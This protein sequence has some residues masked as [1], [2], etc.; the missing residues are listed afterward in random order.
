MVACG[1]ICIGPFLFV[2][3]LAMLYGGVQKY[4]LLQR[5]QNTPTS[6]VRSAAV[7]LAEF[8][9]KAFPR[10]SMLSPVTGQKCAYFRVRAEYYKEG[11]HGGWRDICSQIST[12]PFFLEDETGRILVDPALAEVDIP[13]DNKFEGRISPFSVLG[14]SQAKLDQRAVDFINSAPPA[15]K[16][17]L[18][19]YS[20]H[21]LRITEFFIA[22][23]DP[24]YVMGSAQPLEGGKSSVS[25]ENLIIRKNP[26]ENFFYISDSNEKKATY[27]IRDSAIWG[28]ILGMGLGGIGLLVF[29]FSF[30]AED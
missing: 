7:G 27:K 13:E 2:M 30:F 16:T 19:S 21:K 17:R 25:H 3:G 8:H 14:V 1:G 12:K 22:E 23:G 29:V 11:K 9:G 6:K 4:L 18:N 24:L 28:I 10:E 20:G 5:V 15:L 26:N